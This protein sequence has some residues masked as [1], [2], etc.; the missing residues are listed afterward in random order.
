MIELD[1]VK[2]FKVLFLGDRIVDVYIY[3]RPVGKAAKES[4][5]SCMFV[6]QEHFFGGVWAAKDHLLTF[7]D[8][9]DY[10]GGKMDM[11]NIRL[12]DDVYQRKLFVTHKPRETMERM[13]G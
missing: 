3:V 12:V 4:A 7:V 11:E 1:S 10:R 5:L 9:I 6:K 2:N 8:H 13:R